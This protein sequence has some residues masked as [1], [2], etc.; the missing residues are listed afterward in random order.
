MCSGVKYYKKTMICQQ[1]YHVPAK[2]YLE[3]RQ[4]HM[5]FNNLEL[6]KAGSCFYEFLSSRLNS[7][8]FYL[9]ALSALCGENLLKCHSEIM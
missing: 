6:T 9:C 1:K 8:E 5:V 4:R 7:L 2:L 3:Q